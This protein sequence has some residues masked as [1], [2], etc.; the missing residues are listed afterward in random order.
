MNEF[1]Y[2][3]DTEQDQL[4]MLEAMGIDSVDEL[5]SD[6]PAEIRLTEDLPIPQAIHESALTKK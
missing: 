5:F 1:R 2:L 4:D 6:I 3:P